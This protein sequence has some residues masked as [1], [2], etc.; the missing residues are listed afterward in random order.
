MLILR[1]MVS[2]AYL[3]LLLRM[4]VRQQVRPF[5]GDLH[6][7]LLI[8][9]QPLYANLPRPFRR[10]RSGEDDHGPVRR[11][12]GVMLQVGAESHLFP[13]LAVHADLVDMALDGLAEELL[14]IPRP[15]RGT[16]GLLGLELV[17]LL[18]VQA[19]DEDADRPQVPA[20]IFI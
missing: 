11:I 8:A 13:V 3:C 14:A 5:P 9:I 10:R 15:I 18:A 1:V 2:N 7:L 4:P 19:E 6:E 20:G 16:A 12:A 17:A